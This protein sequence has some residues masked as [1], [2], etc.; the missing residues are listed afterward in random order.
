VIV[1]AAVIGKLFIMEAQGIERAISGLGMGN[2]STFFSYAKRRQP[3]TGRG[4]APEIVLFRGSDVA[5]IADDAGIRIGLLPEITEIRGLQLLE[6]S[7]ILIGKYFGSVRRGRFGSLWG[8][9]SPGLSWIPC[10]QRCK[11][12]RAGHRPEALAP[13]KFRNALEAV[14]H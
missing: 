11:S 7:F 12:R 13:S 2:K 5:S 1:K 14:I 8:G 10:C 4:D 9:D 3:K 6:E